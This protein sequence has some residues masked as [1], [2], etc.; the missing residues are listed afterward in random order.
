MP[1]PKMVA[2]LSTPKAFS[3]R[4]GDLISGDSWQKL[5]VSTIQDLMIDLFDSPLSLTPGLPLLISL[6]VSNIGN[7]PTTAV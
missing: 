7:G 6:E 4:S 2:Q 3:L 5:K 1:K